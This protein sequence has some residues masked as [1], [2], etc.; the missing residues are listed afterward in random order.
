MHE[1]NFEN[2]KLNVDSIFKD[3]QEN[4]NVEGWVG[5]RVSDK[6]ELKVLDILIDGKSLNPT[7]VIR[8]DVYDFYEGLIS[9]NCGFKLKISN[10]DINK[11]IQWSINFFNM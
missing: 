11:K 8:K 9:K 1:T 2:I 3:Q 6:V 7:W 5:T 10:K 4:W